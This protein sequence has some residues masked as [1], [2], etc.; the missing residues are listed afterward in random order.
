MYCKHCGKEIADDSKFC[1]HCGGKIDDTI[2][3]NQGLPKEDANE[4]KTSNVNP[5]SNKWLKWGIIYAI[6]VV[7]N[8]LLLISGKESSAATDYFW[9]FGDAHLLWHEPLNPTNYDFTELIVYV[10]LIPLCIFGWYKFIRKPTKT[11]SGDKDIS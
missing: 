9:P 5:S 7:L 6:Y 3:T 1:Q 8:V 11:V 10:F 2:S 4:L